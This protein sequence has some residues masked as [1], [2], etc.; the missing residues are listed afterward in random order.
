MRLMASRLVYYSHA[1][2][3]Q[4]VESHLAKVEVA[5]PS[6][7]YRS[8][9]NHRKLTGESRREGDCSTQSRGWF[10]TWMASMVVRQI[11]TA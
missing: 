7:V 4:L 8:H 11:A 2:V 1:V 6:P 9:D 10:M 3:S 5:G